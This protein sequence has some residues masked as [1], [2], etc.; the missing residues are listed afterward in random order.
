MMNTNLPDKWKI[1]HIDEICSINKDTLSEKNADFQ[2]K[3]IDLS[4]VKSG[5]ILCSAP[6]SFKGSPSRARRII[7][8][9]DIFIHI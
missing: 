7:R 4:S 6:I 5:K 8:K 9:N 2:F 1:V 3:Y